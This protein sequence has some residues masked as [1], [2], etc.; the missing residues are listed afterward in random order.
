MFI[1]MKEM[2][3]VPPVLCEPDSSS[4]ILALSA[5]ISDLKSLFDLNPLGM[6]CSGYG[7]G[8]VTGVGW[9]ELRREVEI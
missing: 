5:S 3:Y 9:V 4:Q 8:K 7:Y 6:V 1:I 2:Y